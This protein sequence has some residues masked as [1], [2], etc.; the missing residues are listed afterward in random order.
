M[1]HPRNVSQHAPPP[2]SLCTLVLRCILPAVQ[3]C[4]SLCA[5]EACLAMKVIAFCNIFPARQA[6]QSKMPAL[7]PVGCLAGAS[8][9]FASS[10]KTWMARYHVPGTMPLVVFLF[11]S[12]L[13][14]SVASFLPE[15]P[16]PVFPFEHSHLLE[17]FWTSPKNL[18]SFW[19][20]F[21]HV[22]NVWARTQGCWAVTKYVQ[23]YTR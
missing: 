8:A 21:S 11:V 18:I 5:Q 2:E 15:L 7:L 16:L 6:R 23:K 3:W 12:L 9:K 22:S 1:L 17:I 20:L 14:W 19:C 4:T 10:G 13:G